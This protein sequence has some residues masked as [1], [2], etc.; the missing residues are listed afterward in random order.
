MIN[1]CIVDPE[2]VLEL[3]L[4]TDNL[5][6]RVV[7]T[8]LVEDHSVSITADLLEKVYNGE[9]TAIKRVEAANL[10]NKVAADLLRF[11]Q[12]MMDYKKE[13]NLGY[14]DIIEDEIS[15]S[16]AFTAFKR[17]MIRDDPELKNL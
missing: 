17:Q 1:P 5:I 3:R 11:Q 8:K 4:E 9:P 6:E 14:A 2:S 7:I 10:R 15:A 12:Y 13:P 16:S